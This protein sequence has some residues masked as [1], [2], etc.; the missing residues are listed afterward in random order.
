MQV[1]EQIE[2]LASDLRDDMIDYIV[3]NA[4]EVEFI[5]DPL[6]GLL[7]NYN[8]DDIEKFDEVVSS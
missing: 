7:W 1:Y 8:S 2:G 5:S 6:E 3:V 4:T